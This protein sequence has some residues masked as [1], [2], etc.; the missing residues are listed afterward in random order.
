MD[1]FIT[2]AGG[3]TGSMGYW[4]G[5][6]L[7]FYYGLANTFPLCDRWFCS[8]LAQTFPNRRYVQAAT[9][10]GIVSTDIAEVQA[11]PDAPNGLIWDRLDDAGVTWK[12]YAVDLADIMLFPNFFTANTDHIHTFNDFLA[13]L[14]RG[15]AA[16][17]EH[18]QPRWHQVVRGEPQRHP[19]RRGVQLVDH[20]RGDEQPAVAEHGHVLHLRRARR[21]LRPRAAAARDRPRLD[22]APHHRAAR[23]ARWRSTGTACACRA[24]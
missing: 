5:A 24:S 6:D 11:V 2:A 20:Q 21:L 19:A 17:G 7:P 10:V 22:R 9:S 8:A 15:H 14:R 12:D 18:H 16:P 4:T 23:P 1:G 13:R 3:G